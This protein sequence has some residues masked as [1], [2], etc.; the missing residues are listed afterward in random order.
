MKF[1]LA[2]FTHVAP[3]VFLLVV[4]SFDFVFARVDSHVDEEFGARVNSIDL[5]EQNERNLKD[6]VQL[7]MYQEGWWQ[8][9]DRNRSWCIQCKSSSCKRGNLIIRECNKNN[10]SQRWIRKKG[11][12]QSSKNKSRCITSSGTSL[13]LKKCKGSSDQKW[14]GSGKKFQ[15]KNKGKCLSQEHF[16]S[17]GE[18][19]ERINCKKAEQHRTGKWLQ[20]SFSGH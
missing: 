1:S 11:L 13:K 5:H 20:G 17:N 4:T 9:S 14:S 10:S 15:L 18:T 6:G 2:N 16:P 19:L 3:I 7:K 8:G 12:L